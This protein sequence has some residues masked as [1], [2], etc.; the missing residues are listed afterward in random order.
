MALGASSSFARPLVG[1]LRMRRVMAAGS[2][3]LAAE[4]RK[5]LASR[6]TVVYLH[7]PPE[8][9]YTREH[10]RREIPK[11]HAAL[12]EAILAGDPEGA[13][14]A[15]HEHLAFVEE[16]MLDLSRERSR[17]ERSLRRLK[18]LTD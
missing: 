12:L 1:Y 15:A 3:S 18:G 17:K 13:R 9:L 8:T 10:S 6:G 4:N 7:A 5:C 11:Q 16:T 14:T 2:R